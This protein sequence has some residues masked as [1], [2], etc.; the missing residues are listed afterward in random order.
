MNE[1]IVN[2]QVF[3]FNGAV[4][5]EAEVLLMPLDADVER[6]IE[7]DFDEHWLSHRAYDVKPGAYMLHA[8]SDG[9]EPGEREV[10]VD[11]AGLEDTVFLGAEGMPF[12][13]KGKVKVPFEPPAHLLAASFKAGAS[14]CEKENLFAY[15]VELGLEIEESGFSIREEGVVVFRVQAIDDE[16]TREAVRMLSDHPA[17][18]RSGPVIH[19]DSGS[20]SFLTNEFIVQFSAG[21]PDDEV[22][23]IAQQYGFEVVRAFSYISNGFLLRALELPSYNL[24][25][26]AAD[27]L[28]GGRV[29]F[30]EPNMVATGEIDSKPND[31]LYANQ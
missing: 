3:D 23:M 9:L 29:E 5:S 12:Y 26:N 25:Q 4:L 10:Y 13:Y 15:A 31:Y 30:V 21:V 1:R 7:F 22:P 17:I 8:V 16:V 6:N 20:I 14:A 19:F 27:L 28:A 2:I 24:L 18:D 11:E